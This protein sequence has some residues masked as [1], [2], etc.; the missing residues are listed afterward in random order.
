MSNK[1][2]KSTKKT[3][4]TNKNKKTTKVSGKNT[5]A[6]KNVIPVLSKEAYRGLYFVI[7]VL[8]VILSVLQMGFIGRFFDTLFKY[9]FGS[10]S[11]LIYII[12]VAT[13]IYYIMNKK[14][15]TPAIIVILLILVD[16]LFQ[17]IYIGN[18]DYNLLGFNNIYN[19]RVSSY[20]GGLLS[21][22]PVKFLI[23]LL[24][25]YGSL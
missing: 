4:K 5:S 3:S 1:K 17:L 15:K 21:Y 25:Y 7:S 13:P 19:N 8:I 22:Y 20:G 2:T 14:L 16:F 18:S 10:F 12:I 24:S 23:Y 9:L 11:Y 6:K